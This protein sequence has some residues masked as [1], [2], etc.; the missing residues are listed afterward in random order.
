MSCLPQRRIPPLFL[1]SG[2]FVAYSL[3]VCV[4]TTAQIPPDGSKVVT[5]YSEFGWDG[6]MQG[7]VLS[8]FFNGYMFTQ[9]PGG[10]LAAKYGGTKVFATGIF[11]AGVGTI[12]TP[13]I[14]DRFW[15]LI[16]VRML[17]GLGE[18]VTYPAMATLLTKWAP[19]SEKTATTAFC[20]AGAYIGT[21]LSLP[22]SSVV[23]THFGWRSVYWGLGALVCAWLVPFLLFVHDSPEACP[24][25]TE[26]E[27]AIIRGESTKEGGK[28]RYSLVSPATSDSSGP[29][30][31]Q[32]HSA[33]VL[34][35]NAS[36]LAVVKRDGSI[37]CTI[38]KRPGIW[39][40]CVCS[41]SYTW[42]LYVILTE[43]P[44][45]FTSVLQFS[46]Q[47]S[48]SASFIPWILMF[49]IANIGSQTCDWLINHGVL[50]R[51][52]ARRVFACTGLTLSAT[53][54]VATAY[55]HNNTIAI[56][57]MTAAM[58]AL[59]IAVSAWPVN[60]LELGG[61]HGGLTYTFVNNVA[62][63]TGILGP[64]VCG[65]LTDN[66]GEETGFRAMF[67]LSAG[68]NVAGAIVFAIFASVT[69]ET[70]VQASD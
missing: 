30:Q 40:C 10:F 14:A 60:A 43:L 24:G 4:S 11:L 45:Y 38:L 17:T 42:M 55:V 29:D 3:R 31:S 28:Q 61:P 59:G 5:M 23:M 63:T 58:G 36:C 49:V 7:E 46:V 68:I 8:A 22:A 65:M 20:S 6:E 39:A 48:N 53:L 54:L 25:I 32:D 41:C 44:S 66:L 56:V 19:A 16:G 67:W 37:L 35:E 34:N 9:I 69:P 26:E 12:L 57:L 64:L 51:L 70:T 13:L 2:L 62:N 1:A 27:L 15:L 18:G 47:E 52:C 50:S 33:N 21:A